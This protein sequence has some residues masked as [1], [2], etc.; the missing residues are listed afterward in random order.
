MAVLECSGDVN[1]NRWSLKLGVFIFL[2]LY[3]L[4]EYIPNSKMLRTRNVHDEHA[5]IPYGMVRMEASTALQ[6][7]ATT[8]STNISAMFE[9]TET[10]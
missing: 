8:V 9:L 6:I 3:P 10:A 1:W 5:S 2:D 7:V 4:G